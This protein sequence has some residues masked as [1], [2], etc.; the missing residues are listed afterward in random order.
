LSERQELA[1]YELVGLGHVADGVVEPPPGIDIRSAVEP[2]DLSNIA[3]VYNAAFERIDDGVTA[4]QVAAYGRHPGLAAPGVFLA[5]ER[6]QAVGVA[7]GRLDVPA[8]GGKTRRA[9]V[10]LLAVRPQYRR[11]GIAAALL[12]RL[13]ASLA[14]AGVETVGATVAPAGEALGV[15]TLLERYGFRRPE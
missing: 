1:Y 3:E 9:A 13:L 11:Q 12:G 6:D 7:V 2:A 5:F 8:P 10:E 15:G 4:A 14:A